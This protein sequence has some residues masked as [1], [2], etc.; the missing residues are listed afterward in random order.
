[1]ASFS[2][3]W[4]HVDRMATKVC[5]R[6][7]FDQKSAGVGTRLVPVYNQVVEI[8]LLKLKPFLRG[9]LVVLQQYVVAQLF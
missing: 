5:P 7:I 6:R 3:F 2:Y 1:M 4:C 8:L 9:W